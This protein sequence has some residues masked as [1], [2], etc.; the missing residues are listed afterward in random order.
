MNEGIITR[1]YCNVDDFCKV[2][3]GYCRAR[4]GECLC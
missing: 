4:Q 1:I 2:L 3:E